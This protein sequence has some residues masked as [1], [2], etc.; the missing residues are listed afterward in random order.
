MGDVADTGKSL[1]PEAI[2]R[3]GGQIFKAGD[4]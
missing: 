3:D 2:C 4:L 1:A